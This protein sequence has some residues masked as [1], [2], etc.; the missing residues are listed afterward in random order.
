MQRTQKPWGL[1][2]TKTGT[3]HKLESQQTEISIQLNPSTLSIDPNT[4]VL[5]TDTGGLVSHLPHTTSQEEWQRKSRNA[6]VLQSLSIPK[7]LTSSKQPDLRAFSAS[8][9]ALKHGAS[10]SSSDIPS[11][12]SSVAHTF[13]GL[14]EG[15]D[16]VRELGL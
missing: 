9:R 16:V 13:R 5:Q 2:Q 10:L 6:V 11:A 4:P 1:H 3:L 15:Q 7:K 8:S 12:S 14:L